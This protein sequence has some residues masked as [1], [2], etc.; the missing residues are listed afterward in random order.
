MACATVVFRPILADNA[1]N[2]NDSFRSSY[3]FQCRSSRRPQLKVAYRSIEQQHQNR[4]NTRALR[5][6]AQ[7]KQGDRTGWEGGREAARRDGLIGRMFDRSKIAL[8]VAVGCGGRLGI[9]AGESDLAGQSAGRFVDDHDRQR[10][11]G[12]SLRS[13]DGEFVLISAG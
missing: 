13:I 12:A 9:E 4:R 10:P 1:P 2:L 7:D 5:G 11:V 3:G 6:S 8:T